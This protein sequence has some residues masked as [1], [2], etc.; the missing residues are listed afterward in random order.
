MKPT[1][2]SRLH[3]YTQANREYCFTVA[4]EHPQS[5]PTRFR[6]N[7]PYVRA[8][9]STARVGTRPPTG[10][11]GQGG[12]EP[13]SLVFQ[14][15]TPTVYVT[16]PYEFRKDCVGIEPTLDEVESPVHRTLSLHIMA[17]AVRVELTSAILETAVLAFERHPSVFLVFVCPKRQAS[18]RFVIRR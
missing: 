11:V 18:F 12:V 8:L 9:S 16:V 10:L 14:T 2:L 6:F 7:S 1:T 15:N 17:G 3:K 4:R 5:R 13:P